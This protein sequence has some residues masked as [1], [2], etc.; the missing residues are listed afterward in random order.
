MHPYFMPDS[1]IGCLEPNEEDV[2]PA[3]K[4]QRDK[5]EEAMLKAGYKW[6]A[7]KKELIKL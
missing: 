6:D 7:D 1:K 3:T 5:L 2:K 4:E